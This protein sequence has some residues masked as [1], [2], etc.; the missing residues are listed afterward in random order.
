MNGCTFVPARLSSPESRIS[1]RM[2]RPSVGSHEGK[3]KYS[4]GRWWRG[5]RVRSGLKKASESLDGG[6]AVI[7]STGRAGSDRREDG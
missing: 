5:E 6:V 2:T 7:A 3:K 1:L 4:A